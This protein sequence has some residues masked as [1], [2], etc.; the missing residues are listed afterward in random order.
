MEN[1]N[2]FKPYI[3]AEK[4]TPEL[5]VTSIVMGIILAVV[6]GAANA[7]LGLRVGMTVSASIPA[8][9]LSMGVIRVLMKKNSILESNIV[10]TLGSAGESVAA[11]AI[12]TLPAL[13]LWAAEGVME[14]PSIIEITLIALIGG[15][16]G[17]LF[18]VPLRNAL[19]VK[20]HGVLPYPEGQTFLIYHR[21]S[22]NFPAR[23]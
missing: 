10:Q 21:H 3:P 19:I 20:E 13:F 11:G 6:F 16:L 8:A 17:V 7:Y 18:M 22:R 14:K 5:T 23:P 1:K 9:V 4:I 15:I 2:E 12:F